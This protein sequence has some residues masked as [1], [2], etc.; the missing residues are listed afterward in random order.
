MGPEADVM[1]SMNANNCARYGSGMSPSEHSAEAALV[2]SMQAD[3]QATWNEMLQKDISGPEM[4]NYLEWANYARVA[5]TGD[6]N[7]WRSIHSGVCQ[8]YSNTIT[9]ANIDLE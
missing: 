4:C 2:A 6:M 5:L 9:Q 8:D 1:L 3:Y 7:T